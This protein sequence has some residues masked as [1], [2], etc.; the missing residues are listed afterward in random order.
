MLA[1]VLSLTAAPI[2]FTPSQPWAPGVAAGPRIPFVGDADAD[3]FADIIVVYPPGNCIIDVHFSIEGQKT[4][5]GLQAA[6]SWGVDC[7]AATVGDYDEQPGTD[8]CGIFEGQILR[9]ATGF[10]ND[11]YKDTPEWVRLPEK[12]DK[13]ALATVNGAVL[14]LSQETGLA[15]RVDLKDRKVQRVQLPPKT[16]WVGDEGTRLVGM[17]ADGAVFWMDRSDFT[18]GE[19]IGDER[20]GSRP[21]AFNGMVA[22]G[23]TLLTP[24]GTATLVSDGLPEAELV[25]AFGDADNDG[26]P[27]LVEFRYGKEKFTANQVRLRRYVSPGEVDPDH[28]GLTNL[29]ERV[30]KTDPHNPDTDNDGLLDG[31]E[32]DGFRGLDLPALGCSPT[33]MDTVCLISRFDDVKEETAKQG[34]DRAVKFYSDLPIKNPDGS[35][36]MTLHP[37]WLDPVQG[38]DKEGSWQAHRAKYL[39]EKWVG[40]VHWM[41]I[42]PGGGG[43]ADQLGNGGTVG[44][45]AL[46]AVFVHEFGHQMG[47]DHEGFWQN[48]LCPTYTSLMNYAYSY[49][50]DDSGNNIHYSTG[51]LADYVLREN[52]LDETIPLPYER[53]KFLEKGPYRFRLKPNGDTTLIDWNWNG[54]FG[55]KNIRAD[56][57]YSYSTNAGRRDDVGK[58]MSA[59]WLFV[60]ENKAF[61]LFAQHDHP[62]EKDVDPTASPLRPSRLVLRRLV[63]PFEW[64]EPWTIVEGGVIGDPVATS[65]AGRLWCFYQT[66][67]GV[68]SRELLVGAD[69]CKATSAKVID[70][71]ATQVPT[72][73]TIAG[74]TFLFLWRPSDGR[75]TYYAVGE[76]G[77]IGKPNTLDVASTNPVGVCEDTK[78]GEVIV[79]VAANQDDKRPNR[80]QVRRYTLSDDTLKFAK[81]EW[82]DGEKGGSRGTG[83]LTVLFDGSEEAGPE[84]RIYL[85]GLGMTSKDSPWACTYVAMQIAD[86]TV[87]G[88]WLVKR[89]YD[90]WTQTRSAPAAAW[91]DGDVIWAYRWVHGSQGDSDNN[92]HVGYRAL[93]I[94]A[95]PMA[96][97]DDVGFIAGFGI[98]NSILSLSRRYPF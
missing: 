19:K 54:V 35:T 52:D 38:G 79:A 24:S 78:T 12:L 22:F 55:E 15:F 29:W 36:G 42:T 40:L 53:V 3:G 16:V 76:D 89:F 90:E 34:I 48:N 7:Q 66:A 21:A 70:E 61:V 32:T 69:G 91:F 72:V 64:N 41:Q 60:H 93:G 33:K 11:K 86:K 27:D 83:R 92:L 85:Y 82:V 68:V 81:S 46:W 73:G 45:N 65:I 94:D 50:F 31:W 59:P 58:A 17:D 71:D 6:T 26:D 51:A 87:N 5:G 10:E 44:Q 20:P 13:P 88:G 57:N 96:D 97:F 25:R 56:I 84:G 14:A 47:L 2:V 28:D 43:Q 95:A 9:L 74:K 77:T 37:V 39:P 80:W 23:T 4:G 98:R 30:H 63:K 62:V 1:A 75:V 67:E 8:V 49:S 18:R